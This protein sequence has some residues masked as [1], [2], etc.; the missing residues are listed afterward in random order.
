M[1]HYQRLA[2][3]LV[4]CFAMAMAALGVFGAVYGMML[5]AFGTAPRPDQTER[6]YASFW[7][8]LFGLVLFLLGRPLGRLLGGGLD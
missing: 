3:F 4:R 1:G 2:V 5:L 8:V 6:L 7:Y